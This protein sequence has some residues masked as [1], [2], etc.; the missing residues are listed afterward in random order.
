[1]RRAP[2]PDR[3]RSA[4]SARR[5]PAG[6]TAP[7]RRRI[8]RSVVWRRRSLLPPLLT[9]RAIVDFSWTLHSFETL[10]QDV[11]DI[12][13]PLSRNRLGE[14]VAETMPNRSHRSIARQLRAPGKRR[15]RGARKSAGGPRHQSGQRGLLIRGEIQERRANRTGRSAHDAQARLDDADRV[16]ATL[17]PQRGVG[18]E[19]A[20]HRF[21]HKRAVA[22]MHGGEETLCIFR[23]EI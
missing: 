4:R 3:S 17:V 20:P 13:F 23:R 15:A 1:M 11:P 2:A 21:A 9:P 19:E 5:R 7:P 12:L 14:A 22:R 16:A 6:A 18:D 10:R 8:A